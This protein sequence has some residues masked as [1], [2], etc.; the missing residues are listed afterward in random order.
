MSDSKSDMNGAAGGD[1]A[2]SP[3][4]SLSLVSSEVFVGLTVAL[5]AIPQC[6]GF[7]SIA[8]LPAEGF[9]L[10]Q[11]EYARAAETVERRYEELLKRYGLS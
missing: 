6:I 2:G 3:Q 10:P 9:T 1:A 11:S 4:W 7:A 8:G 5:V